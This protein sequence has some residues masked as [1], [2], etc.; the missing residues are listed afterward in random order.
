MKTVVT[1]AAIK[2]RLRQPIAMKG[3]LIR[4]RRDRWCSRILVAFQ[5]RLED[6][7]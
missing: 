7:R 4:K 5:I 2:S 1:A 3:E 6:L